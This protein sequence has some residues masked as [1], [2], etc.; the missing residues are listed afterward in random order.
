[1]IY[2]CIVN[3][4]SHEDTINCIESLRTTNEHKAGDL[5][6]IVCDNDSPGVS[7]DSLNNYFET[8][9]SGQLSGQY[10]F[11]KTKANKGFA[12]G[13]NQCIER[14]LS[15]HDAQYIWLLNPDCLV[16]ENSL[17]ELRDSLSKNHASAGSSVLLNDS[18]PP[19][20]QA[21]WGVYLPYLGA[22]FDAMADHSPLALNQDHILGPNQYM[23]GASILIDID[24]VRC[25]LFF[26]ESYF[27]YFE[28]VDFSFM[29]Y[30]SQHKIVCSPR[31]QVV[32][33]RGSCVDKSIQLDSKVK[34]RLYL[35]YIENTIYFSNKYHRR[36]TPFVKLFLVCRLI[37]SVARFDF[38]K[39]KVLVVYFLARQS[40]MKNSSG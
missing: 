4:M 23:V 22:T 12:Y 7:F 6:L 14:A 1:M 32:H 10:T 19:T 8:Q 11:F 3:Y 40:K 34:D 21:A 30:R 15:K 28:D 25:P 36:C 20:I 31:S 5:H 27:M 38:S 17:T 18:H 24:S 2:A 35:K 13:V 9:F 26:D 33:R 16:Q 37:K 39:A 29:L